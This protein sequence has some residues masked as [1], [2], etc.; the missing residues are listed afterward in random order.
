MISHKMCK[1]VDF[2]QS[3][4]PTKQ[5]H[6]PPY[7]ESPPRPT[8]TQRPIFDPLP[9]SIADGVLESAWPHGEIYLLDVLREGG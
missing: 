6:L 5:L 1:Q 2:M 7:P 9:F 8:L 3:Q 4:G